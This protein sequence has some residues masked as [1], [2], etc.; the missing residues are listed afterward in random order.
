MMKFWQTKSG[1]TVYQLLGGR[2]NSYVITN[3]IDALVVDTGKLTSYSTLIA[4]LQ[5]L[6]IPLSAVRYLVL[7]HTHFDH[8]QAAAKFIENSGCLVIASVLEQE[9]AKRGFTP[10]PKGITP[11]T[12]VI[13][14]IAQFLK[15]KWFSY[16]PF[17][18][19]V[20]VRETYALNAPF[21]G[22]QIVATPGHSVGSI[23]I[24]VDAE[25]AI[26]GD[27]LFGVFPNTILPPYADDVDR[28]RQSWR[29]LL[30]TSCSTFLPGHGRA[31]SRELLNKKIGY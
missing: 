1:F 10:L 9:F 6:N 26:V 13:A 20:A 8:C 31:I 2:S 27:A 21:E 25:L 17:S 14:R 12:K 24:I 28:M 22:I 4:R 15:Q 3:G 18:V 29:L 16:A 30:N 11:V 5:S 19:D 7:T 23:S